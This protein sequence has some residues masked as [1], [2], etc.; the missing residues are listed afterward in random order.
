MKDRS[1]RIQIEPKEL[2]AICKEYE[3]DDDPFCDEDDRV[4]DL[5]HALSK[6]ERSDY[7][8]FC[9]Y[10]EYQSERKV[11]EIL[12]CSRTP[13]SRTLKRIKEEILRYYDLESDNNNPPDSVGD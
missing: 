7:I 10:L 11:A 1:E 3:Y 9:L 8:I 6:L 2:K 4:H 12:G 5:K 13:V